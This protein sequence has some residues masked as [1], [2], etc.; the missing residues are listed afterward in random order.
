MELK[1]HIRGVTLQSDIA[2]CK[3]RI[4]K[5]ESQRNSH[6]IELLEYFLPNDERYRTKVLIPLEGK[7]F[8]KQNEAYQ[9][10]L[11]SLLTFEDEKLN[12]LEEEFRNL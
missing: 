12:E 4:Q 6:G 10:F 9:L 3:D 5:M 11:D 7:N 2:E 8:E 1:E